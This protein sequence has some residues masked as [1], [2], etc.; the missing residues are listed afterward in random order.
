MFGALARRAGMGRHL[1]GEGMGGVDHN[2]D[3]FR[4]QIS[5]KSVHAA[6]AAD[7]AR[8]GNGQGILGAPGQ[9]Q[10]GAQVVAPGQSAR[11]LAGLCRATKN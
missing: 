1:R 6:E 4:A 3:L 2:I 9:R 5:D 11:Q 8:N 7:A 10:D